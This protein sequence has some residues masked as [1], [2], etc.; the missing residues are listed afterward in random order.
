LAILTPS[1]GGPFYPVV[2]LGTAQT[3]NTDTT[4]TADRTGLRRAALLTIVTTVGGGPTVKVDILGSMDG[5]AFFN[6]GYSLVATPNT[7]VSSQITITT[8]TT[9]NYLL[10]PDEP[11]RFLKLTYSLNTNVTLTADL[12]V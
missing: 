10:W 9:N 12:F 1:P 7:E 4:N 3:G 8:A 11:W 5:T 6:I 2:N